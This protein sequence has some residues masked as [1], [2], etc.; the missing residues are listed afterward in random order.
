M[1]QRRNIALFMGMLETEFSR[2]VYEGALLGA[3]EIDANL[4]VFPGGIINAEYADPDFALY[5]RQYNIL[6]SYASAYSFDAIIME[7]GTVLS[8]LSEAEK[9]EFLKKMGDS[10][11]ILLAGEKEG[12]SSVCINNKAGLCE[13][14]SHLIEKHHCKKIGFVS[15][16]K[17]NQD[18]IERLQ[19]YYATMKKFGLEVPE[20]WVAYGDFSEYCDDVV[21]EFIKH[22]QDMDAI[23]FANDQMAFVGYRV[24][25]KYGLKPGK[26]ILVTAYDDS[27]L[28][29]LMEPHLASVK[30]D[31][32]ELAYR[33]VLEV[34]KVVAG[35][36]IHTYVNSRFIARDSCGCEETQVVEQAVSAM[37]QDMNEDFIL[38]LA[39]EM[40]E[41]YY[42]IYANNLKKVNVRK[43]VEEYFDYY[44]HLLQADGLLV[45]KDEEFS[46]QYQKFIKTC[47]DGF[48]GLKEFLL[49]EQIMYQYM[50][51][52]MKR[53]EDKLRLLQQINAGRHEIISNIGNR[54][55]VSIDKEKM[56]DPI[57]ASVAS[58]MLVC[59]ADEKKSYGTVI[60][61]LQK[62]DFASS[63]I[64]VY[65]DAMD[66]KAVQLFNIPRQFHVKAY[67]NCEEVHLYQENEKIINLSTVFEASYI[68][69][70]HRF[71]MLILPL[72]SNTIQHGIMLIESE[73]ETF[74]YA[75]QIAS[76]LSVSIDVLE[77]MKKQNEIKRELEKNLA[78]TVENNKLLDEM[79]RIDPLTGILNRRGFIDQVTTLITDSNNYGKKAIAIYADMDNLK[80]VNDE[81]G[82][83][84]GDYS[85]KVIANALSD[86][87]LQTDVVARMGGD[88]F[89][90]FAL[91]EQDNFSEI[92]RKR[93]RSALAITNDNNDKPYYVNM[94]VGTEEFIIDKSTI[95]EHVLTKADQNLYQ[96]KKNK[97]KIVYKVRG[98]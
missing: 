31:P 52:K 14:V 59:S 51:R 95:L 13:A 26:D 78:K 81:F 48:I 45:M 1:N 12:Y 83:D 20:D 89:A 85:L 41:K 65:D 4:F 69:R 76:Q 30:V 90:A 60:S 19:A 74:H 64:L 6:Y 88:E 66:M 86:S 91:V 21:E 38:Q 79:S 15:G 53:D 27:P 58:D 34:P 49:I 9:R 7:Y 42:S 75:V 54:R 84:E 40:F 55:M 11:I 56:F 82:H 93:I 70:D 87:F 98:T 17:T 2:S 29:M 61:K 35:R 68:P 46:C 43:V 80:I 32:K 28:V 62:M 5:R 33:A 92:I 16:P 97:K 18:A 67:H 96:E 23:V 50:S 94:S 73:I 63:C 44:F 77:I 8:L 22:H 57:L 39:D 36:E 37:L 72:F 25:E 24:M 47:Q 71:D 3:Q 10:P